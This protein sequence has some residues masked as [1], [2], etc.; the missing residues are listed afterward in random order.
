MAEQ[1]QPKAKGQ[2]CPTCGC[3]VVGGGYKKGGV[4]YCCE[5]C[6]AGGSCECGCCKP[7]SGQK[8][9]KSQVKV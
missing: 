6:A 1:C 2:I 8:T 7:V 4:T 9:E 5:P 3:T